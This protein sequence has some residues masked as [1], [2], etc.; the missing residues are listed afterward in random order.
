MEVKP[1]SLFLDQCPSFV[2]YVCCS[3]LVFSFLPSC[4]LN[5]FPDSALCAQIEELSGLVQFNEALE[6]L[7]LLSPAEEQYMVCDIPLRAKR[8]EQPNTYDVFFCMCRKSRHR[9]Y[10]IRPVWMISKE[11]SLRRHVRP[12]SFLFSAL[13]V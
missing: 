3:L 1:S 12:S 4:S 10:T 11:N 7:H 9:Y 6:L 8:T 13:L 2:R 5:C